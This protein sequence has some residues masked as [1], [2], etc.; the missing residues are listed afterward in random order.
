VATEPSTSLNRAGSTATAG[1]SF[2]KN[3]RRP[4][5]ASIFR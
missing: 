1:Y 3:K 5:R 4:T 2:P